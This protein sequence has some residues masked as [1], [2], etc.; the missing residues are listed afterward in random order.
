MK[1]ILFIFALMLITL[2]TYA[3]TN[4][5]NID[6]VVYLTPEQEAFMI[7][8]ETKSLFKTG[9]LAYEQKLSESI[10]FNLESK[11]D[12][13]LEDDFK[14][15]LLA[16]GFN[17]EARNYFKLPKLIKEGK[18]ANNLSSTYYAAGI[19]YSRHPQSSRNKF[20]SVSQIY[21]S[22]GEQKR[23]LN[24]GYVNYGLQLSYSQSEAAY[25]DLFN[26]GRDISGV[27]LSNFMK[28][29]FA[30]GKRYKISDDVKCPIF[31]CYVDRK[32]AFK[33]NYNRLFKIT[34]GDDFYSNDGLAVQ[35]DIHPSVAYE[36]KLGAS[37]FTFNQDLD[38]EVFARSG[39]AYRFD[40]KYSSGF[41]FYYNL[42]KNIRSGKSGNNLSGWYALARGS[43][44]WVEDNFTILSIVNGV[45][46]REKR[47][48]SAFQVEVGLGYQ[49]TLLNNIYYDF[50]FGISPVVKTFKEDAREPYDGV[51]GQLKVGQMF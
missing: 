42:R 14:F 44:T 40:M 13:G 20:R 38:I 5:M 10:S 12:I 19:G 17:L 27:T 46:E 48:S 32:S 35:V 21:A 45:I 41:R 26:Y 18:Q 3:Q 37:P 47:R 22:I 7:D 29:G 24:Y 49:K 51:F 4:V 50:S 8:K 15:R 23:F 11:I 43:Y 9:P 25:D 6:S 30:F 31:K 1:N 28:T 2:N 34:V 39:V 33:V 16:L 36:Y